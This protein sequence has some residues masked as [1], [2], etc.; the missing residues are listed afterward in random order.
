MV[1]V[2]MT[3]DLYRKFLARC[4]FEDAGSFTAEYPEGDPRSNIQL[5]LNTIKPFLKENTQNEEDNKCIALNRDDFQR[6][7]DRVN[8]IENALN[9]L[10]ITYDTGDGTVVDFC[11]DFEERVNK[12]EGK[13]FAH[14]ERLNGID[15]RLDAHEML[16][17][18]FGSKYDQLDKR[19]DNLYGQREALI[20]ALNGYARTPIDVFKLQEQVNR[21]GQS[22]DQVSY[23][24]EDGKATEYLK[25]HRS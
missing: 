8:R 14:G 16:L 25:M 5:P 10:Y 1:I 22:Q 12:L 18:G 19:V 6:L 3:D 20:D 9:T 7:V 15:K 24:T 11:S 21:C 2:K 17:S 4:D 23:S 13:T